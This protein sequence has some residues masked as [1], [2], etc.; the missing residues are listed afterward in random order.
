M[1]KESPD[2]ENCIISEYNGSFTYNRYFHYFQ[3]T[4]CT[5]LSNRYKTEAV[6]EMHSAIFPSGVSAIDS[7]FQVLMML[8]E[9]GPSNLVYSEELYCDSPRT[10]KYLNSNYV[11]LNMIKFEPDN[12]TQILDIFKNK[13]DKSKLTILFLEGCSNPNG[14]VFNFNILSQIRNMFTKKSN[15]RVVIDNT[16]LTSVI[17][18]PLTF[19]DVDIIVNSL[20]K[21]YG[22]GKSGIM[23]AAITKHQ[24]I[25]HELLEYCKIKGLH[26]CP[27]YCKSI[28]ENINLMNSRMTKTSQMTKQLVQY[29]EKHPKIMLVNHTSLTSHSSYA[30]YKKYF[31]EIYP[32][33]FT[34]KVNLKKHDVLAWM[35]NSKYECS[36]SFGSSKSKF[37]QWPK[38]RNNWSL[39]RFSVGFDDTIDNL[40][41]E[42]DNMLSKI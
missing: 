5:K 20:T 40:I 24:K 30:K 25:G 42:F 7:V 22:G 27:L 1:A 37:D 28:C 31:G 6:T 29:L 35:R 13:V 15:L 9:W 16:W 4:L 3:R 14:R 26:I 12:D 23:G 32:S 34:F 10:F 41:A 19:E 36:T 8:N 2:Y 18:N 11:P 21:Y 39:C 38:C 17:F 33:V